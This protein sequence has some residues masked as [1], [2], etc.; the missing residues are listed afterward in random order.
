MGEEV[1]DAAGEVDGGGLGVEVIVEGDGAEAVADEEESRG[2]EVKD[3]EGER[4]VEV[5][6]EVVAPAEEGG[7]DDGLGVV[8]SGVELLCQGVLV[9]DGSLDDGERRAVDAF[10]GGGVQ[11]HGGCSVVVVVSG[12]RAG[13]VGVAQAV[14]APS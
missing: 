13:C 14:F 7:M 8:G 1:V 6:G 12:L 9:G 11:V 3:S 4:A 10:S 2:V 5:L